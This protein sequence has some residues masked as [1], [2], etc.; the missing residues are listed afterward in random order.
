MTNARFEGAKLSDADKRTAMAHMDT[1]SVRGLRQPGTVVGRAK[2]EDLNVAV[3]GRGLSVGFKS[4]EAHE[5]SSIKGQKGEDGYMAVNTDRLKAGDGKV[6]STVVLNPDG[7]IDGNI[8]SIELGPNTLPDGK[9]GNIFE[10]TAV[11]PKTGKLT[12]RSMRLSDD[13]GRP[14]EGTIGDV[15]MRNFNPTDISAEGSE[16]QAFDVGASGVWLASDNKTVIGNGAKFDAMFV[17]GRGNGQIQAG[18]AGFGL[19]N[20]MFKR[21]GETTA[22]VWGAR[23]KGGYAV[24]NGFKEGQ[25]FSVAYA[26]LKSLEADKVRAKYKL[27]PPTYAD[28]DDS[29]RDN[30]RAYFNRG[31]F[32]QN[33]EQ[34]DFSGIG[35]MDGTVKLAGTYNKDDH[36]FWDSVGAAYIGR[37]ASAELD[38]ATA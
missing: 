25:D 29:Y 30:V 3:S 36:T 1:L 9:I 5:V 12:N 17:N 35:R 24:L 33:A 37:S 7:T 31:P 16:L 19:D 32:D 21:E 14:G 8:K 15:R 10:M 11:D 27:P 28:A 4:I 13:L 2:G 38:I 6:F 26:T 18:Y 34:Y 22:W 23:S 20:A